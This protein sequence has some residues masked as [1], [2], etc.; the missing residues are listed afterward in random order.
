MATLDAAV[1]VP[2]LADMNVELPMDGPPGDLDLELLGQ[3]RLVQRTAAVGAGVGQGRLVDFV[4]PL[5]GRGRAVS[6]GAVVGARFA[7]RLP[8]FGPGWTL[9]KGTGLALAGARRFVQLLAQAVVFGLQVVDAA[10][11]DLAAGTP[12]RF[13]ST[14][15]RNA[16]LPE[17]GRS[18]RGLD[19]LELDPLNKYLPFQRV[20]PVVEEAPG[21]SWLLV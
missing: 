11:K 2:A 18:A 17:E 6:L 1:T 16:Q 3:L 4:N 10:L 12:D 21:P 13:H 7:A 8:G 15:I 19:Q 5:R 14:I 20:A 9:G